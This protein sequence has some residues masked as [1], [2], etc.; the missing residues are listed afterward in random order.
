MLDKIED[1]LKD[2]QNGKIVI[3]VDDENRENEGDF[4]ASGELATPENIN[5]MAKEGRGLICTPISEEIAQRLNLYPMAT[6][7]REV[8]GA[9]FRV[10]VDA[11]KNITTG[12][13]AYDRATTI[14]IIA[15]R[16][17]K[18]NDLLRPGHVFPLVAKRY[19]VLR[20][21]GHTE[22][23][24]DLCKLS[25]LTET[26]VICEI[27]NDDGTMARLPQLKKVAKK[28]DIKIISIAN[29]IKYRIQREKT[30]KK[31]TEFKLPTKW[32]NFKGILF[33]TLDGSQEHL[34]MVKGEIFG[35]EDVLVRVHS[36]CLTGDALGSLRCDCGP[37][38]HH[39][40][41]MIE[42]TGS[43]VVLYLKQEGRGI[44]LHAKLMAYRLQDDG[45]DTVEAN[46]ALGF[47]ADLRDY[48]IGAQ[49]LKEL[50]LST[51]RLITNNPKKIIGLKGYGLKVTER[52][53]IN[54]EPNKYNKRYLKTKKDKMEHLFNDEFFKED[55]NENN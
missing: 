22:A 30:V 24:I 27:M 29:L 7:N 12:I 45:M 4:V 40:M 31:I 41:E 15:D 34:A 14:K 18:P 35:K 26:A 17:S 37:Q 19:G 51:I 54:I 46:E 38:L 50:G 32:G 39:S 36:E 13:S 2:F 48:G 1:A 16:D 23:S 3:I 49:I 43:G 20:R 55:K 44:G 6:E 9:D 10:S 8:E 21:A 5:F 25:K 47:K 52:V 11:A 42:E 33:S 28:N 53:P